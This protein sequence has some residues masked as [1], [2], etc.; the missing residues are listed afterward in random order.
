MKKV[1]RSTVNGTGVSL[2]LISVVLITISLIS[3]CDR[4]PQVDDNAAKPG[5]TNTEVTILPADSTAHSPEKASKGTHSGPKQRSPKV[6]PERSPL[7]E[8][9]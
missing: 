7:D 9:V 3:H 6:Y 1:S 5:D 2:I 8:P 4:S